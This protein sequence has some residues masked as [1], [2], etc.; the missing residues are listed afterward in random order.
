MIISDICYSKKRT[1]SNTMSLTIVVEDLKQNKT[2]LNKNLTINCMYTNK[3][4]II[5]IIISS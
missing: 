2:L 4:N 3:H 5:M 1:L